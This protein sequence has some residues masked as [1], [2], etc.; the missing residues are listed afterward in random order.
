MKSRSRPRTPWI[1]RESAYLLLSERQRDIGR[2]LDLARVR[3]APSREH[4]RALERELGRATDSLPV[5]IVAPLVN[6]YADVAT[7]VTSSTRTA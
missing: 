3:I 4:A 7:L 5:E 1:P 6:T 2:E